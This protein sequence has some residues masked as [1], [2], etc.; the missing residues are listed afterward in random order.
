MSIVKEKHIDQNA[1]KS[2]T[3]SLSIPLVCDTPTLFTEHGVVRT[4]YEILS[5]YNTFKNRQYIRELK[6]NTYFLS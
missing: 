2:L 1:L 3:C 6:K 5:F 4:G